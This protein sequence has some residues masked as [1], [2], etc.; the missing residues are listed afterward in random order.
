MT[1]RTKY[2]TQEEVDS[3][4]CDWKPSSSKFKDLTGEVN[5]RLT[6]LKIFKRITPHTFWFVKCSCGNIQ[7]LTT[8]QWSQERVCCTACSFKEMGKR[9]IKPL[10][11]RLSS[12]KR[13][14]PS[15]ELIDSYDG[16]VKTQWLWYCPDCNTP[17]HH[18]VDHVS[19]ENK[20]CRCNP[21]KFSRWTQSLRE[22]QIK[23]VCLSRGLRFLGWKDKYQNSTSRMFLKCPKHPHYQSSV[24]NFVTNHASYGC[25]YCAEENRGNSRKHDNMLIE[26]KG[27]ELF[28]GKFSY[29]NFEYVDS[30]TPSI[31]VCNDCSKEFKVSFDNH[32]NKKRGCP[33]EKGRNQ[34]ELYIQQILDKGLPIC[35]KFGIATDSEQRMAEH[36]RSTIYE[37][38]ALRVYAFSNSLTCKDAESYIKSIVKGSFLTKREFPSGNTETTCITNMRVIEGICLD[39]GGKLDE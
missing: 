33:Y 19:Q 22:G 27:R 13:N 25:P 3:S 31:V 11:E 39:F 8:N 6:V 36:S 28:N 9:T 23:E 20:T 35:I 34:K 18:R 10:K 32:I 12:V 15:L 4:S 37:T 38:S 29:D 26:T 1:K 2:Y 24:G 17:Y 14:H 30:R 7:T 16:K 5:G 21:N